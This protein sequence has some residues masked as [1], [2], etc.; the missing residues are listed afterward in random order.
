[1]YWLLM[2]ETASHSMVPLSQ[3]IA[4]CRADKS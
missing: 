1:M 2:S 3:R 4:T